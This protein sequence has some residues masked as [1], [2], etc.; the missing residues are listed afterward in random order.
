MNEARADLVLQYVLAA[1][2]ARDGS[3]REVTTTQL[4]KYAY[5]AD[6]AHAAEN[7]G[8][9]YTG[10][11]W[12]FTQQG[13]HSPELEA[14][15]ALVVRRSGARARGAYFVL[16]ADEQGL[17]RAAEQALPSVVRSALS[18]ALRTFTRDTNALLAHV[19][20]TEPMRNAAPGDLVEFPVH[21]VAVRDAQ[22]TPA[23]LL[24]RTREALRARVGAPSTSPAVPPAYPPRYDELFAEAQ[25]TLDAGERPLVA[26]QGSLT[27]LAAVWEAPGRRDR[28]VP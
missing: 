9:T 17:L 14:R 15:V 4:V 2:G 22:A 23:P 7:A 21:P 28:D 1:A 19:Y 13:P 25:S 16:D 18:R 11:P 27:I 26:T 3:E 12:A 10:A 20:A 8:A 24:P 5:L 6:L